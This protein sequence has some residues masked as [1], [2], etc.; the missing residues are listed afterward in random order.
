LET[1]EFQ[2]TDLTCFSAIANGVI[3]V[4]FALSI[5][6]ANELSTLH[7]M[8]FSAASNHGAS[9]LLLFARWCMQYG[10]EKASSAESD[11][12][13]YPGAEKK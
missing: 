7:A 4:A 2:V 9:S 8:H 3:K 12:H 6:D 5:G 1:S 13:L 11:G 10:V